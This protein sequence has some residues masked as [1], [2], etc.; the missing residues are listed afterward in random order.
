MSAA[1]QLSSQQQQQQQQPTVKQRVFSGLVTKLHENFGF[2]DEDVI[3]QASVVKGNLS[4]Q[5]GDRVLVE[6]SYNGSM[7]F[8]WNAT[9]VQVIAPSSSSTTTT[10]SSQQQQQ[11]SSISSSSLHSNGICMENLNESMIVIEPEFFNIVAEK[12]WR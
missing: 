8:K 2:I 10:P 3:F 6:A 4:P 7:P 5:V 1:P 9:R 11:K 12:M